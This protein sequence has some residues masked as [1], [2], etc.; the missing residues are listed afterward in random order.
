[1]LLLSASPAQAQDSYIRS[2]HLGIVHISAPSDPI[3]EQRYRNALFLGAGWNRWPLYW[4]SI[5]QGDGNYNWAGYDQLVAND[6]RYG[7][8]SDAI[9]LGVPAN[10]HDGRIMRG[11]YEPVFSDGSDIPAEGKP[12]NPGNPYAAFVYAAVQRYKPGGTLAAQ[13]GWQGDQGIRV[14]EAWNEPDLTMFWSGSVR[15]YARLLKVTYMAVHAADPQASVMFGGLAY[16]HP[17]YSDWFSQT[18]GYI[19]RDPLR[20]SYRWF[21]DIAAVHSYGDA[22]NSYRVVNRIKQVMKAYGLDRPVWLNESGVPVWDDY[23][24][25]T[26][27][28]NNP[29]GRQYRVTEAQ[30]ALYVVQSTALA[31]AAGADVVFFFQ[32][33]DD[34]GNQPS[35]TTFAP[36]TGQAGDAF[37]LFRNDRSSVCFNQSPQPNTPRPA[38]A[39]FYRM[40]QIFGERGFSNPRRIDLNGKV[41]LLS[42]DLSP[43]QTSAGFSLVSSAPGSVVERAYVMWNRSRDRVVVDVPAS[44]ASA[45]LYSTGSDDYQLAPQGGLYS[46]GLPPVAVSDYPNLNSVEASYISGAPFILIEQVNSGWTPVDPQMVRLQGENATGNAVA[47]LP[48]E[49]SIFAVPPT[50][51]PTAIPRPTLDPALDTTPPIPTMQALPE[52]SP[53]TFRVQWGAQDESGIASYIVWVRV[54]GGA[55]QK[56]LETTATEADYAGSVGNTYE[57]SLWAVDLA[58]NW[59]QNID[60]TP[61][62]VTRVK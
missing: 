33:Y 41:S 45:D 36:N 60:L 28:G 50:P 61:Q 46:I 55:W 21:F 25:P 48:T 16:L 12:P 29:A 39:A 47:A 3:V 4:D 59:S 62:A 14:W 27:T 23:P 24:G 26:W 22:D 32:L 52:D 5:D 13:L 35:G 37:G 43:A 8:R 10:L 19:S 1:M 11:L 58:G 2:A 51:E 57:F 40:A 20:D 31:W 49:G 42:F 30:Q 15:D 38:A 44:S 54:D 7:L 34:C 18:L 17:M 6:V 9:F 56:W 53:P